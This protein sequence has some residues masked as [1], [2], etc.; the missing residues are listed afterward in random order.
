[1]SVSIGIYAVVLIFFFLIIPGYIA[2]RFYY[3][4]EFSKQISW[5]NNG[6]TNLF[7]SLFVGIVLCVLYVFLINLFSKKPI[8]VDNF[9]NRFDSSYISAKEGLVDSSKFEG[10]SEAVYS[11]YLPF[12]LGMSLMSAIIGFFLS[13]LV[14]FLNLDIR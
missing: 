8:D 6:I 2:R 3:N 4:G 10:F 7:S 12:I 14:L 1:M 9:L 13:K 11:I 5:N